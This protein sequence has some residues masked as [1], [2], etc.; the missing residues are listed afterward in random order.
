MRKLDWSQ[1]SERTTHLELGV[2]SQVVESCYVQLELS[3]L[4]EFSKTDAHA[5]E[6][7]TGY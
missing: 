1:S 7:R 5:N 6:V 2:L 4:A 3:T